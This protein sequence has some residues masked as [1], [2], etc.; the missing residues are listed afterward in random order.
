[1]PYVMD[2]SIALAWVFQDEATAETEA[3]RDSLLDDLAI[4]PAIW[5]L[6]IGNAVLNATRSKRLQASDWPQIRA[7]LT[8]LPIEVESV[9]A[10]LALEIVLPLADRLGLSVYDAAYLELAKRLDLPLATLDKK[11]AVA[12]RRSKVETIP[13]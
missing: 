8:A 4:V 12:A 10:G 1:M 2:C 11:L 7:A 13:S 5:P 9:D 3:L 6:E